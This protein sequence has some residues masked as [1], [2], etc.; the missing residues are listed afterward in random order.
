[1]TKPTLSRYFYSE[2]IASFLA[3]SDEA[4]IGAMVKN[5]D[6]GLEATQRDA[7]VEEIRIL[8]T[9]LP[10]VSTQ[11]NVYFEYSIPRLGKRVDVVVVIGAVLF[12]LEFKVGEKEYLSH[13]IDQVWDYALDLKNF[14]SRAMNVLLHRFSLQ[15]KLQTKC[16][17]LQ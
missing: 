13:A 10:L 14:M 7:W 11:G 6:F 1:M 15:L 5:N 12:V 3:T 17:L 8:K 9:F 16:Q 4:I 2:S